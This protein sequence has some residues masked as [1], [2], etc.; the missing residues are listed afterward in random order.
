MNI[1]NNGRFGMAAALSG[2]MRYCISKAVN[3]ATQRLQFG[4][5]LD[6]YG[7]IQEKIA[8]M[9]IL[10]YITDSLAYAISGNMDCG[11]TDY[12]LEAAISKVILVSLKDFVLCINFT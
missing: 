7:G 11:S 2:T 1:L 3:H 6:N 10:H 12:H 4:R 8:R 5:T 9:S